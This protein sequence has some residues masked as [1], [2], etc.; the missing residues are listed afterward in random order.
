MEFIDQMNRKCVLEKYPKRII[1]LVP[2]QSELLWDLGLEKKLAGITKFC[3]HP[4]N[5]FQ[6]IPKIGGT[7]SLHIDKIIALQPDLIIGNKEENKQEDIELLSQK[8]PVWMSDVNSL[9]DAERLICSFGEITSETTQASTILVAFQKIRKQLQNQIQSKSCIYLIWNEP[10]FACGAHTFIHSFLSEIGL[11]NK[12]KDSRYPEITLNE[13]EN[14][15]P[16][17]LFLS[18]EPF[19]F[20][21]SHVNKIQSKLKETKVVLVDGEFFSWYGSRLTKSESYFEKLFKSLKNK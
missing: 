6:S 17:F 18:T 1:S 20:K 21:E 19:P 2:S 16:D 10:Y 9:D 12:I 13:I 8:F 3:I 14:I 5:M 15:Q 7:K 11:E 4:E